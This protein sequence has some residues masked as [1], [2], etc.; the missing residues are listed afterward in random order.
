MP[1]IK[2]KDTLG[3]HVEER[4]GNFS[5]RF[6]I[7]GY[8]IPMYFLLLPLV[9]LVGQELPPIQSFTPQEYG[10]ENQN[11]SITQGA[12]DYIY[13]ANNHQLLSYDGVRWKAYGSP[14]ASIFRSVAT[15]DSLIFTGQYMEFGFWE[16]NTLGELQYT[17]I[18]SQLKEPM[19][20][21]EEFWN[22][23][24][25]GDW[26]LFQSLDRIYSYNSKTK[27]FRILEAKTTKAQIFK[28]E[29]TV[30]YQNQ[31]GA[32]YTIKNGNA[33]RV[34]ENQLLGDKG[35]VGI[36][37][38]GNGL[39]IILEDGTFL[40]YIEETITPVELSDEVQ[41]ENV[42]IYCTEQL[43]DGSYVLGTI[44]KGVFQIDVDSGLIRK[45]DQR[46]GLNNNTVLSL[47]QDKDENLWLGLDNGLGVVNLNS[48]FS[49]Y[50]DN[51]GRFGLVYT[52]QF[53]DGRLYLGTNQGLFVKSNNEDSLFKMIAGTEGQ[54]WSL[55]VIANA[56][57]CGHNK[58]TFLVSGEN[59]K[60]ISNLPGTWQVKAF[61]GNPNLLMQGNYDGLSI[62]KKENG[63]WAFSNK[64][65]GFET[66][67]RFF[68]IMDNR[69][70][71]INHEYKGLYELSLNDSLTQV[72][73][74]KTHPIMGHGSSIIKYKGNLIYS[75]LDGIFIK[76]KDSLKFEVDST[77]N[78][79]LF[80]KAGGITSIL[81][82]DEEK[83]RLWC[84]TAS[85]LSYIY[86]Q[87]FNASLALKT[88]PIPNF[89]RTSLGV[90][91]FENISR[92]KDEDYLIGTTNGYV[93]L[94]ADKDKEVG[95]SVSLN[96]ITK[97]DGMSNTIPMPLSTGQNV[98]FDYNTLQFNYSV[99]QY[100]K[101]VEVNYQYRLAGYFD[102][103]SPWTTEAT[104]T[105]NNLEYGDYTF[106]IRA[107]VGGDS[108]E[109]QYAFTVTR[110]WYFSFLA[111]FVYV[112]CGILLFITVHRLYKSYY[113]KKQNRVLDQEKK[114][115]KRKKLKTEKELIQLR[116][117]KLQS[118]I[119]AKNRE[120]AISTMSIVKKNQFLN[121]IKEDLNKVEK[122]NLVKSIIKTINNNIENEDD[123]KFFEEAFNN[124]DKDFL[125]TLQNRHPE[126]TNND[127]KLC[128]YLRLNLSSK[129]IAPLL[130]ISIKS[131]EVKR[132]R[133]RKKMNLAHESGL[134]E[135]ILSL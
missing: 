23:V 19:I 39:H 11:W 77:L 65:A 5:F 36:Y 78:R 27:A 43:K 66:S 59:A 30:Y 95:Y 10:G 120:L 107:E 42:N 94:H 60:I 16:E 54:V 81:I 29:D 34:I 114:K 84:Y 76:N 96:T 47:F 46:K 20:D 133:L 135:Y 4:Y 104:A 25:L 89:F 118:E 68:E 22:I 85:G 130:N 124:T 38:E 92:I 100:S 122:S 61:P 112:I 56:L 117:E 98:D 57:F 32:I 132:Y 134:T 109:A 55:Q 126:L 8:L 50:L 2:C 70:I 106:E 26:I 90:S 1:N 83:E 91:G 13:I 64:V 18:S 14:N 40:N 80:E 125:K 128:A 105:F 93:V 24:V 35:V 53:F 119:D 71:L 127:L 72:V 79:L 102:E 97:S 45:I 116:N 49:E 58:G 111:I 52:S 113:T 86:P 6:G 33:V 69:T 17:S 103:W 110:P 101:Y 129:E 7:A 115:L 31:D 87:T 123:W 41:L 3:S 12:N 74:T 62:L 82:S 131:V 51:L 67:S 121:T 75:S 108:T 99:P 21:D 63:Q 73:Q 15:K 37:K 88:V 48:R 9:G 28:I 44:S